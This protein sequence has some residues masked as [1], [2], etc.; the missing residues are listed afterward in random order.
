MGYFGTVVYSAAAALLLLILFS[1]Y[2]M[3]RRAHLKKSRLFTAV[4]ILICALIIPVMFY[5]NFQASKS[6]EADVKSGKGDAGLC[7]QAGILQSYIHEAMFGEQLVISDTCG[8]TYNP[9]GAKLKKGL[10]QKQNQE[11]PQ[12]ANP[13]EADASQQK[14]KK[15]AN[16]TQL[17]NDGGI[18]M[19]DVEEVQGV[20]ATVE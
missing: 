17:N 11:K 2:S 14:E 3:R 20:E 10:E 9:A 1:L 7:D 4:Q 6:I 19:S 8:G 16:N 13:S 12:Q 18:D 15:P 5:L